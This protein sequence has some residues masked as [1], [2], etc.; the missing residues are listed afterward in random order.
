MEAPKQQQWKRVVKN[1]K[2]EKKKAKWREF[3]DFSEFSI[4]DTSQVELYRLGLVHYSSV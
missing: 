2:I 4:C 3:I 1:E